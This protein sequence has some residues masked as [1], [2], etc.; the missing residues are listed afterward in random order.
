MEERA[1]GPPVPSHAVVEAKSE[2]N[3][4]MLARHAPAVAGLLR[5]ALL[6]GTEM[7]LPTAVQLVLDVSVAVVECDRRLLLFAPE[8]DS[9]TRL[10][11]CH[12]FET[13]DIP[14][15][16]LLH[17]WVG[18]A[19]KPVLAFPGLAREMDR[20][21]E[22]MQAS[23]A[24]A[25]PLF[26]QHGWVGSIQLFRTGGRAFSDPEAQ[27]LWLLSL[28]A[29]NQMAAIESI[30]QLT[31]VAS[32]DYLT[33]LRARGYFE[34][35][36]EQEV[37]R[38]LRR[39]SPCGLLLVDLDDFKSVNDHF[40][41]HAGDAVLREFARILPHGTREVDTVARFGGDEFALI[42]PDTGSDGLHLVRERIQT[43]VA[44]HRFAVPRAEVTLQLGLSLGHAVCPK[45]AK[46][47]E[48]LLRVADAVLYQSKQRRAP[49][50]QDLRQAG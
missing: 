26:L 30:Q 35:A 15:D 25:A 48:A 42:L 21:L 4:E 5:M 46:T 6:S 50:W 16:N 33:G 14:E 11:L 13:V 32:T 39:S 18:Q 22:Q 41:H 43:A 34:R 2:P 44:L 8:Q 28:L 29:E 24:L 9:S 12:G 36:L 3:A 17:A 10:R 45:D 1:Q 47:P 19:G 20:Y 7:T 38:S 31:R 40:G 49:P 27:L 37:H 23:A